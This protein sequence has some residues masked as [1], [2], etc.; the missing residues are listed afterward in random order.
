MK[1]DP[2]NYLLNWSLS[3]AFTISG[4]NLSGLLFMSH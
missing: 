4:G 1:E 3:Y 2:M